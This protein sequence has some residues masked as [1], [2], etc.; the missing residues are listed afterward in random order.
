MVLCVRFEWLVISYWTSTKSDPS[1][2][3]PCWK[4][5]VVNENKYSTGLDE[6]TYRTVLG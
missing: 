2:S 6:N 5:T 3:V 4:S 1:S